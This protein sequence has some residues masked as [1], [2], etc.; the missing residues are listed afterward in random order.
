MQRTFVSPDL[1]ASN[2]DNLKPIFESLA[3][4]PLNDVDDLAAWLA[5]YSA[6]TAVV[7]EFGARLRIEQTCHTD[8]AERE[9][10]FM[11]YIENIRPKLEPLDFA[12]K[13][14]A[15]ESGLGDK[16][17]GPEYRV[18]FRQWASEVGLYRE[19]NIALQ[20]ECTR[21]TSEYD[22]LSG[23]MLIN[24][25]GKEQTLQQLARY[26]EVTDR[27]VRE[28]TWTLTANRRMQDRD[29]I[30]AIFSELLRLRGDMAKNAELADY[31]A[32]TWQ[33]MCRFDYTPADC[34]RFADAVEAACLPVVAAAHEQRR[35]ALGV[36][37]LRPWD[38]AVDTKGRSPLSPFAA[39]DT[40]GLVTGARDVF[41]R[42]SPELAAQFDELKPGRNLDLDSRKGKRPGG[43][44][45]SLELSRQ[46]FIFMN[47]AGRHRDV[48]TML[49][50][51]G[52]AFHYIAAR[53]LPLVFMRHAPLEFCEV[54]S[55]SMELLG[56][57]HMG[58]F[59]NDEEVG[60]AKREHLEGIIGLLPWIAT[61]D[62]FQQ[63]LYT[64][65]DHTPQQRTEQWLA[66]LGRFLDPAIDYAGFETS[67]EAMWHRQ[68]HLF[69]YPFY[70]IEY[71]IAQL[72]ALQVWANFRNEGE[73]ALTKL[74]K[75]FALGGTRSLPELFEAAGLKFDFGP[76]TVAPLMKMVGEE[77]AR[78]PA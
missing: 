18:L 21:K 66:V 60:R 35:E 56:L 76:D 32:Y 16:L 14:K 39:D 42:I 8:D 51:G 50:E 45:S 11:H 20:T 55:M 1:D 67:R 29:A 41:Q 59:Y 30:D 58:V 36:D 40:S 78:L 65:P 52:H 49:H 43:Y 53:D 17:E 70:Y 72:G 7:S 2:F 69:H 9:K 31:R 48:E 26:M 22:K 34:D 5:D 25:D 13:R 6:I 64:H 19:A 10:A 27:H 62:Q 61:I 23:A 37:R 73:P 28:E 38:L 68:L 71:G 77:L 74:R 44:Q 57:E 4:R 12:L 24:Y 75:A 63:W 46:P 54:A 15:L 33:E 47:A 3:D